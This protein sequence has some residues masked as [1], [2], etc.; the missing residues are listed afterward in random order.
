VQLP[1]AL[2]SFS[3]FPSFRFQCRLGKNH[4]CMRKRANEP[5]P[6]PHSDTAAAAAAATIANKG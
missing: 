1:F 2:L 4:F 5:P 3:Y 6:P